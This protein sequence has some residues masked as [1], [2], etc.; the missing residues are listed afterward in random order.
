MRST[1][2]SLQRRRRAPADSAERLAALGIRVVT[3]QARFLDRRTVTVGDTVEVQARRFIIATGSVPAVPDIP[4]LARTP[5]LSTDTI[6][7]SRALPKQLIVIGA[8]RTGLELAQ[9]FGRLGAAVT[10]LDSARPLADMDP[11]G[12]RIVLQALAAEGVAV[13][14]HMRIT[15]V[16]RF[17][18]KIEV[19][20]SDQDAN[21]LTFEGSDLLIATGRRPNLDGLGLDAAGI[22]SNDAG[23]VVNRHLRTRNRRIYAIGDVAGAPR[24]SHAGAAQAQR[25]VRRLLPGRIERGP[26]VLPRAIFTDPELAEVGLSE[27]AARR[28]HRHIQVLRWPYHENTRA[29]IER[30]TAGHIKVITARDGT[31]LGAMIAGAGAGE[32]IGLWSLAVI[33][34]TNIRVLATMAAPHPTLAEIVPQVAGTALPGR[35]TGFRRGRI[36]GWLRRPF[37]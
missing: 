7:Q 10:V 31:I 15:A 18:N 32:L 21:I 36:V 8:G 24:F 33:Q 6:F 34:G 26:Q 11:E 19:T 4:G 22:R 13:H 5:Y 37:G 14:P 29:R 9:A 16:R 28:Q 12:T 30:A 25:T 20:A 17:R 23:I 27:E 3:G 1:I 2:S 35:L